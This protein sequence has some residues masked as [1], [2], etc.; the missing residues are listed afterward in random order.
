MVV[1]AGLGAVGYA[2][3]RPAP[4]G[5]DAALYVA[6]SRSP[7]APPAP[8]VLP[9]GSTG[10]WHSECGRN[11]AGIHNGDNVVAAPGV[12]GGAHHVHDYVGNVSTNAFSTDESLAAADT[13]CR[14]D[15]RSSYYWPVLRLPN[16]PANNAAARSDMADDN[17]GR[18]LV[19]DGVLLEFRGNP[20]SDVVAM[21]RF[22]RAS[23]GSPHGYSGGGVGA[24]RVQ[25]SCSASRDHVTRRYPR[26]PAGQL[27]VRIFDF[28]SCWNGRT[29]D[30]PN[31]H[32]HLVYPD[33]AGTCPAGTFPVPQLHMEISYLV[34]AGADY[35]IDSFPQERH[36]PLADHA[37]FIDVMP[38]SLMATAVACVNTG[39]QC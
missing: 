32:T 30:S 3:T 8:A 25:W 16:Q 34:P 22:L 11:E 4:G 20:A 12:A 14:D 2:R 9:G 39:E 21:P 35:T 13:T 37:D 7:V 18:I 5:A 31:H 38:D 33:G 36:S 6:I 15:D 1:L 23:A 24:E 28:P 26:C 19:P 27:V 17:H 10:T 29:T